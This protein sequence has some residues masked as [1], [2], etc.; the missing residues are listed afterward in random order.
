MM[1]PA[2]LRPHV[3]LPSL[4]PTLYFTRWGEDWREVNEWFYPSGL[5]DTCRLE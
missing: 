5:I 3:S 2:K 1:S 4:L